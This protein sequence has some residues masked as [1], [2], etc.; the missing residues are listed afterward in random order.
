MERLLGNVVDAQT[1]S[2]FLVTATIYY[3]AYWHILIKRD[4]K[5]EKREAKENRGTNCYLVTKLPY[6]SYFIAFDMEVDMTVAVFKFIHQKHDDR[7]DEEM[8]CFVTGKT[9]YR[10]IMSAVLDLIP[11]SGFVI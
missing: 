11:V 7:N 9:Y 6:L 2:E 8:A 5:S 3:Y 4:K 10:Q 1:R